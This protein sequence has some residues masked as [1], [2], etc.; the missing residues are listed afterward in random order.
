M[1]SLLAICLSVVWCACAV[2]SAGAA[3]SS[4][5]AV[6]QTAFGTSDRL[7]PKSPLSWSADFPASN[8]M[9]VNASE[10]FQQIFGF[11]GAFTE[12]AAVNFASLSPSTQQEILE[13]YFG[14]TGIGYSVGRV[15]MGSC[16]FS[17]EPYTFADVP[18]DANLA[19]FDAA[20]THD[21]WTMIPFIKAA[22]AYSARPLRL[23]LSPW[24]PPAWMKLPEHDGRQHLTGS[25]VPLG[26][27]AT[28]QWTWALYYSKFI[29]AYA[30]YGVRFWGLTVQNEPL[31]AAPWEACVYTAE[32][33]RDL[34]K[35]Y[36]GPRMAKDHPE[37]K[38]M[39]YDHNRD[40]VANFMNILL[41][42]PEC[43]P[44]IAG[45]AIHWYV[46]NNYYNLQKTHAID[47]SKFILNTEA[48]NCPV[49]KQSWPYA[50]AYAQDI[51]NDLNH[52]V[53]GFVD[54][55]MLVDMNGGPN[56]LENVCNCCCCGYVSSLLLLLPV[57]W[58]T[59]LCVCLFFGR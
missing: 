31:F 53:T 57:Y 38:I 40:E 11:G 21:T 13:L 8:S 44:Y 46:S 20:V 55:N 43:A 59:D 19:H 28:F 49:N 5:V 14:K 42:D 15:P 7:T 52:W 9:T 48:C 25:A 47:P 16:D 26:L 41:G 18:G 27:N 58:L 10:K 56:H 36:L 24:S 23:Y 12:A 4:P 35:N 6:V 22:A 32:F 37:V 29:S 33:Q 34:I 3:P 1:N 39:A 51:I 2:R 17:V 30:Q 54:W 50:E 45:T